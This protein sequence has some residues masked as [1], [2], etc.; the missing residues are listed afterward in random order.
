M[1]LQEQSADNRL[2]P[3]IS[4][5]GVWALALGTTI[6]WG[7]LVIT[8]NTYLAQAG[9]LGS[10][11]GFGLGA[12][13]MLLI[14]RT[15][16]F[17][18]NQYPDSGGAYAYAKEVF[19]YDH[20]FISGWFLSLTYL[21]ILW[22]N[23][24]SLPL[25]SKYFFGDI[26][27]FGF[28]YS[29]FGYEVYL[30]EALISILAIIITASLLA[31]FKKFI[32]YFMN[33]MVAIFVSVITICFILALFKHGGFIG[34][35]PYFVEDKKGLIQIVHIACISPWAFIGFESVSH[36][37]EEFSFSKSKSFKILSLA[38]LT[39][40]VLYMFITL[41]SVFAYPQNYGSWL[42][43]IKNL[44]NEQGLNALPAF[45]AAKY[46]L[47]NYGIYSLMISLLCLIITSLIGNIYALS[48]LFYSLAK[49]GV[50]SNKFAQLNSKNI[51]YKAVWLIVV[52]SLLI[53]F[54]GRTA[55]SWIVDVTTICAT[56]IY[57]LVCLSVWKVAKKQ[58]NIKEKKFAATG[59]VIMILFGLYILLPNLFSGNS[60]ETESYFLFT[61]WSIIGFVYFRYLLKHDKE[62][63]FGKSVIVWVVLLALML[64]TSLV[65]LLN[66]TIS[67][68][69]KTVQSIYYEYYHTDSNLS[70]LQQKFISE[71]M[72]DLQSSN[73]KNMS[74]FVGLFA[75]SL[76]LLLNNYSIVVK[77]AN[78]AEIELGNA[79]VIANTDPMTGV[80]SK[81]AFIEKEMSIDKKIR[82]NNAEPFSIVV[83]DVNGLKFINDTFGH[84]AGDDYIKAASALICG[85]FK[86]SPV[87][88]TGG[89]EFVIIMTGQDYESRQNILK[90]LNEKSEEN[91]KTEGAVV[92]SAGLSDFNPDK[93][94]NFHAVFERADSLMYIRKKE[95]K[96]MG[97]KTRD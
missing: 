50:I 39:A 11:F 42:E 57:G 24:T 91:I 10:L 26:L 90:S 36:A 94:I 65:W 73:M 18:M 66:S 88:R 55:I 37:T 6:G 76:F 47:G 69:N 89:D 75:L 32:I 61:I 22:A 3:Y 48:R 77:R 71:K 85:L 62:K 9:T 5:I 4:E 79:L 53:P 74:V 35:D 30:G 14:A 38:V 46:Y 72:N 8:S 80:K 21:A 95:L 60:I 1:S 40:T 87:Y 82:D 19:G 92:V 56:F 68:T 33:S 58:G 52:L 17:M 2:I 67:S 43:Y 41:L 70:V 86:H 51:P 20:A 31:N 25:F 15:Y 29:I 28:R 63:K 54:C 12:I 49:D 78:D 16:H 81:H 34:I 64:F 93:D 84:K 23:A 45:Y 13:I 7:S 27:K 59:F 97:A 96:S 83:C 44:K